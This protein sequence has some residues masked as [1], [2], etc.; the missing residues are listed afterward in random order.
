VTATASPV[1]D[2]REERFVRSMHH[3]RALLEQMETAADSEQSAL[4]AAAVKELGD[5]LVIAEQS[6]IAD[7]KM[8]DLVEACLVEAVKDELADTAS[9]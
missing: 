1:R 8:L 5:L 3:L 4:R 9:A 2:L 7:Q 6:G